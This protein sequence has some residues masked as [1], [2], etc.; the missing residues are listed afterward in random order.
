MSLHDDVILPTVPIQQLFSSDRF[1]IVDRAIP[2]HSIYHKIN[3]FCQQKSEDTR[4]EI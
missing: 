3:H 4:Q 2:R 1:C